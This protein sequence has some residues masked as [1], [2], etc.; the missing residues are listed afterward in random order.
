MTSKAGNWDEK[1]AQ[2]DVRPEKLA[3]VI[4]ARPEKQPSPA[5]DEYATG[6]ASIYVVAVKDNTSAGALS[7]YSLLKNDL[8]FGLNNIAFKS[9]TDAQERTKSANINIANVLNVVRQGK[10]LVLPNAK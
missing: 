3:A 10:Y 4:P 2:L 7:G 6:T 8:I 9:E 5:V 1:I